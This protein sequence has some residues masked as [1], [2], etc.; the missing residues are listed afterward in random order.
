MNHTTLPI[1][2]TPSVAQKRQG[3]TIAG[4]NNWKRVKFTRPSDTCPGWHIGK[5]INIPSDSISALPHISG[6][7]L[8]RGSRF[9]AIPTERVHSGPEEG[10]AASSGASPPRTHLRRHDVPTLRPQNGPR[11]HIHLPEMWI[12]PFIAR[13]RDFMAHIDKVSPFEY[14]NKVLFVS[15][16]ILA[17]RW[18][19]AGRNLALRCCRKW[20]I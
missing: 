1:K 5:T 15:P 2:P 3:G 17:V 14:Y 13:W 9:A 16:T 19:Y 11:S 10:V 6:R 4:N 8:S 18:N 20:A 12:A 7:H